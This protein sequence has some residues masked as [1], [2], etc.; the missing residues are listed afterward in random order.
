M[1]SLEEGRMPLTAGETAAVDG[2]IASSGGAPVSFTRE[3]EQL[4]VY[5]GDETWDVPSSGTAIRRVD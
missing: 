4:V 1:T 5:V 3:G 2:L